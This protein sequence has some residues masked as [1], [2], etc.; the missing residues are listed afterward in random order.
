MMPSTLRET[1][2]VGALAVRFLVEASD[3]NGGVSVF[4]CHVPARA[5]MPAPHS[6]DGFEETIYGLEGVSTWT[7]D[8][9]RSDIG[10]GDALCVRRGIVHGFVND[11]GVDAKFLAI[12]TP[13][14]FGAAYF[15]EV[16]GV[17]AASGGG[18]PDHAVLGV[19]MRR[20]GLTPA[21]PPGS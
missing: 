7:V 5:R 1:I 12:A 13:G 10:P 6:H 4:E 21:P 11:G 14:V 18:P 15:R 3:S 16:G 17:L 20:H 9:E 2:T 19:V 8:G